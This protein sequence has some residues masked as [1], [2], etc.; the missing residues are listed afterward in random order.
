MM[1]LMSSQ[2]MPAEP[3]GE[4][5]CQRVRIKAYPVQERHG[6]LWAYLGPDAPPPPL[7]DLEWN[8]VP[9]EQAALHARKRG[10]RSALRRCC[11]SGTIRLRTKSKW[12]CSRKKNVW[13]VEIASIRLPSVR[14]R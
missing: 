8:L 2:Q 1:V 14:G 6:V 13:F 9:E 11:I 10:Q 7:P 3:N 12:A 4:R 5:M